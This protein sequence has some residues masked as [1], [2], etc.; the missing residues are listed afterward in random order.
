MRV[1]ARSFAAVAAVLVLGLLAGCIPFGQRG[2]TGEQITL[3][4]RNDLDPPTALTAYVVPVGGEPRLLGPV[5]PDATQSF[6]FEPLPVPGYSF[7]ATTTAGRS[8]T[9]DTV[10]LGANSVVVWELTGNTLRLVGETQ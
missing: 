2:A 10:A 8:V 3:R 6:F 7:L 9:S 5:Q 1:G 4:V